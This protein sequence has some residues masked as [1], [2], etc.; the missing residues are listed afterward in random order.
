MTRFS[1]L[2]IAAIGVA[3]QVFLSSSVRAQPPVRLELVGLD[4]VPHQ[5]SRELRWR[6]LPEP[7][8]GA[9]VRLYIR[10]PEA[11]NGEAQG[12]VKPIATFN[13]K[14]PGDLLRSGDWAWHDTP[15]NR[16]GG[17]TERKLEPGKLAVWTFNTNRRVCGPGEKVKIEIQETKSERKEASIQTITV[18][19][20]TPSI[21]LSRLFFHDTN[22]DGL[23]DSCTAHIQNS[24]RDPVKVKSLRVWSPGQDGTSI[25]NLTAGAWIS[26]FKRKPSDG[27]ITPENE[28]SWKH[29]SENC[30]TRGES[31]RFQSK[32]PRM[33]AILV[34]AIFDSRTTVLQSARVGWISRASQGSNQSHASHI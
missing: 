6:R 32:A 31:S 34:G 18:S 2:F 3:W 16:E 21:L 5:F 30:P 10:N 4:V 9:L 27:S 13:G 15:D 23:V 12:T 19:L 25:H 24:S 22:G 33:S 1:L 11:G 28:G 26:E 17:E 29:L 14:R 7:E 8:L 20:D